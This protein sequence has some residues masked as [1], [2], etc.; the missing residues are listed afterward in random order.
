[1]RRRRRDV[2]PTAVLVHMLQ[3]EMRVAV[4]YGESLRGAIPDGRARPVEDAR[5]HRWANRRHA[6]ETVL[7][8]RHLTG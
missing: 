8:A 3:L 5:R 6:H 2:W 4:I 1:M 7:S